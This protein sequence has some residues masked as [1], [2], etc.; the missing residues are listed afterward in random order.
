MLRAD[1]RSSTKMQPGPRQ[2][3]RTNQCDRDDHLTQAGE[4][5]IETTWQQVVGNVENDVPAHHERQV[6]DALPTCS[7]RLLGLR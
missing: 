1:P 4:R 7:A 5:D 6:C 3:E 2:E